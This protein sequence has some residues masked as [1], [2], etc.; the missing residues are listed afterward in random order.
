MGGRPRQA[1][2]LTLSVEAETLTLD[3]QV[4]RTRDAI[5]NAIDEQMRPLRHYQLLK[6]ELTP[7][8]RGP[9]EME[10]KVARFADKMEEINRFAD[11]AIS[12]RID[13]DDE[14]A[15][16]QVAKRLAA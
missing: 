6:S 9:A 4:R 15:M 3:K 11:D 13:V 10:A 14:D 1:Q 16:A 8:E 5:G 12:N 2:P 7:E